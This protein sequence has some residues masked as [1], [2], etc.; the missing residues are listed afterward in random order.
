MPSSVSSLLKSAEARRNKI[1]EQEDAYVAYQ[2]SL[3]SKTY[4][5]FVAY[6]AYLQ[7][8]KNATDDPSKQLSYQ[9]AIDGARKGYTSN[10]IQRQSIAV[11]EGAADNYGKYDKMKDLYY[12]AI[13]NGDYDAAQGLRLQLDNLSITIQNE[14]ASKAAAAQR[15]YAAAS[16]AKAKSNKDYIDKLNK[17]VDYIELPQPITLPDGT[18]V[19]VVKPLAMI[20]EELTK[21]GDTA[22]QG[23]GAGAVFREAQAT[24]L[25][26]RQALI[27]QYMG[28]DSQDEIDKL[29][30]TYGAGLQNID[31]K[32]KFTFGGKS[33]TAQQLQIAADNQE[34][35]NPLY[36]LKAEYNE[37]TRKNEYRLVANN[38]DRME[39]TRQVDDQGNLF[40][41]PTVVRTS[42]DALFFGES[43]RG[44]GLDTRITDEGSIIGEEK[45]GKAK[46]NLGAQEIR[47]NKAQSLRERLKNLGIE[48]RQEGTTLL[49]RLPGDIERRAT[50]QPDGSIRFFSDDGQLREFGVV[51][52]NL[53]TD[54]AP[55][56]FR[57]GEVRAVAP[58]ETS[59]FAQ[60]SAFG[61]TLSQRSQEGAN[62][63][64]NYSGRSTLNQ[65]APVDLRGNRIADVGVA[66]QG[67]IGYFDDFSGRGAPMTSALLQSANFTQGNIQRES[68]ARAAAL[69]LQAQQAA[70]AQLQAANIANL[71]QAPVQQF[72]SNGVLKRQLQVASLPPAPRIYVAPPA[73][74][75]KISSVSVAQP[76]QRISGVVSANAPRVV[77]R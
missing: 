10:E 31:E 16:A 21:Q 32:L 66:N 26:I 14:E 58:D 12:M 45:D 71:N 52:R 15:S 48:A 73:P 8:R 33:L 46:T 9:K 1:R 75:Q 27:D 74:A 6:Q 64:N 3:S 20:N 47:T 60:A 13:D 61:G 34:I 68:E 28:A 39:Y 77:V 63:L 36:S 69:A 2:Y 53:G 24:M 17:G 54:D 76:T 29:E 5:D 25:A 65:L 50:I 23:V 44:R 41:A 59:D 18:Q 22:L 42:Q 7:E 11:M 43:D 70:A 40:Y 30:Q 4:D 51:D 49:I 57:A 72:A 37:A 19:D 35:N 38:V 62:Y 55:S 67:R 56:L